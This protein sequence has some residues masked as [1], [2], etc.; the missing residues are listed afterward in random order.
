[1][2]GMETRPALERTSLSEIS[3]V[4]TPGGGGRRGRRKEEEEE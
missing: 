4:V 1:M 3:H 2:N